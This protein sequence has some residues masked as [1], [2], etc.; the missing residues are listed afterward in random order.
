MKLDTLR[1]ASSIIV[2]FKRAKPSLLFK[3]FVLSLAIPVLILL[4][5]ASL[6]ISE[7]KWSAFWDEFL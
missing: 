4:M 3:I 7:Q 1:S 5:L 6:F 2:F